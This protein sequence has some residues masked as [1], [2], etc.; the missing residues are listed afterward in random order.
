MEEIYHVLTKSIAEYRIFNND[1][2][3][4]RMKEV[5]GYY[6][7]VQQ[8]VSF[9]HLKELSQEQ[10]RNIVTR[11]RTL[12]NDRLVEIIAYCLMPTHL[13]LILHQLREGGISRFMNNVLNSYS[14]YFN[15]KHKRKGPLWQGRFKKILVEHEEQLLHLTRYIHLNPVTAYLVNQAEE[16]RASS[17]GEYIHELPQEDRLCNYSEFIDIDSAPYKKF[18]EEGIVNQRELARIQKL[19][20]DEPSS[21]A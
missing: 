17:Y 13:H 19:F 9:S 6:R 14:R 11:S 21:T 5:L 3:F 20:L 10:L 18:V 8:P 12:S 15:L 4:C 2:D 1:K 7:I 16:W